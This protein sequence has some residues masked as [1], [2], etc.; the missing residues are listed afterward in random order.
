MYWVVDQLVIQKARKALGTAKLTAANTPQLSLFLLMRSVV[1]SQL[2]Y[3]LGLLTIRVSGKGALRRDFKGGGGDSFAPPS[4]ILLE[5]PEN[6]AFCG[7]KQNKEVLET[8]KT[9]TMKKID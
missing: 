7:G 4:K 8:I 6:G 9:E 3:G 2:E 5:S 1:M